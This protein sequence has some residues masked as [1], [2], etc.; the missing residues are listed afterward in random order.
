MVSCGDNHTGAVDISGR[1]WLWGCYRD[2][3]G[4]LGFPDYESE[5]RDESVKWF[6]EDLQ[7]YRFSQMEPV[8][9]PGLSAAATISSGENHTVVLTKPQGNRAAEVFVFGC[10]DDGQL[11]QAADLTPPDFDSMN[12][13]EIKEYKISSKKA[14]IKKLWPQLLPVAD[15]PRAAFATPSK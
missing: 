1:V 10:D 5:T 14:K 3:N 11:G 7:D 15:T 4:V 6:N 8:A 13:E 9:V 12:E 2:A